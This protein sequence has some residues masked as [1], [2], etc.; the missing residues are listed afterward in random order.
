M[1]SA[2]V[3]LNI[4]I[5]EETH[6]VEELKKIDGVKEAHSLWGVY[7]VI[8]SV[9]AENME[10]LRNIITKRIEKVGHINSKL[11]MIVTEKPLDPLTVHETFMLETTS[12]LIQ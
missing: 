3:L 7:D 1:P 2:F 12:P 6:V 4:E 5:G 8:A 11:T 10:K 9:K